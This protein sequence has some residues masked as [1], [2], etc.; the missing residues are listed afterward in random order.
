MTFYELLIGQL[1]FR[2]TD[3]MELVHYHIAK[4]PVSVNEVNSDIP[5]I[6]SDIVKKLMAKNAGDRYQSAFGVKA[7]L[8]RMPS[9]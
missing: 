4:T 1:P 2:A 6:V 7:D 8:E 3:A 5:E 9:L